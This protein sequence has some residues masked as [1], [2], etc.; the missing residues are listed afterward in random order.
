[1]PVTASQKCFGPYK[2]AV[3]IATRWPIPPYVMCCE[4]PKHSRHFVDRRDGTILT[5]P[6]PYVKG[7]AP[8]PSHHQR[9]QPH[10][11]IVDVNTQEVIG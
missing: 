9:C 11:H 7:V 5:C 1:M 10:G 3:G 6:G 8:G 2:S 4:N